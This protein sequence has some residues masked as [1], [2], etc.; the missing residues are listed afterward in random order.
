MIIGAKP[1][2]ADTKHALY[3]AGKIAVKKGAV[4][5][6]PHPTCTVQYAQM[7]LTQRNAKNTHPTF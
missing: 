6:P 1:W 5:T 7:I 4:Y 3:E 2:L